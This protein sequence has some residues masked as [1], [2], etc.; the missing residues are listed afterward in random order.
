M[1]VDKIDVVSD[2]RIERCSA[3]LNGRNYGTQPC[4]ERAIAMGA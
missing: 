2:P 4:V 1:A 3:L